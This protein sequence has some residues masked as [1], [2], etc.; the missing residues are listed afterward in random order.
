MEK[1]YSVGF[2]KFRQ[3]MD[4]WDNYVLAENVEHEIEKF[5]DHKQLLMFF[6]FTY[7]KKYEDDKKSVTK[8]YGATEEGRLG[9]ARMKSPNPE[10]PEVYQDNFTAFDLKSLLN[11]SNSDEIETI[12]IFNKKDLKNIKI[13]EKE[14]AIEMLSKPKLKKVIKPL[15]AEPEDK[16]VL[17]DER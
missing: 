5:L 6:T 7:K 1:Q 11:K 10:D 2:S 9:F 4:L 8:L 16:T 15:A 3:L 17:N 14:K 13:I 12:K